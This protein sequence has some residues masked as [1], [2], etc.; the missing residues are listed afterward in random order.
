MSGQGLKAM[1]LN[2]RRPAQF[3]VLVV[4]LFSAVGCIPA[5]STPRRVEQ[6]P[7]RSYQVTVSEGRTSL[8]KYS[9]VLFQVPDTSLELLMPR[10]KSAGIATPDRYLES[11]A[12]GFTTYE[13]RD[14]L[15]NVRGYLVAPSSADVKV[16]DETA[17][18]GKLSVTVTPP[19]AG[20]QGGDGGGAY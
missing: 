5:V 15:G 19:D 11:L 8:E 4:A 1:K 6:V 9:A 7:I 2:R 20:P 12:R 16:W 18:K 17:R 13:L 3:L 10:L 14:A